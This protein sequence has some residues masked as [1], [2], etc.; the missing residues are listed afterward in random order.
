MQENS[1]KKKTDLTKLDPPWVP[2]VIGCLKRKEHLLIGMRPER[3][4]YAGSWEFPGGKIKKEESP[5]EA[6]ERE[7]KEE[8]GILLPEGTETLKLSLSHFTSQA[9]LLLLF[10]EVPSWKRE[11]QA[12]YHSQ[13][14]W[15]KKTELKALPLIEA[16]KQH[17]NTII[18]C[19]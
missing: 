11:V 17:L 13:L 9:S 10:Y 15:V 3:D 6:L 19:L 16:N 1:K 5:K 14:K 8:L 12:L 7:L 4:S 2:V 18:S